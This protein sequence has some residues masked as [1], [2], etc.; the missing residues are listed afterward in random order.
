[1]NRRILRWI[2][3]LTGVAALLMLTA[4]NYAP[5]LQTVP[6]GSEHYTMIDV[7][8]TQI[9]LNVWG[10]LHATGYPLYV[11]LSAALVT[12]FRTVGISAAA[13]PALT[14][15]L[16]GMAALGLLYALM[17]KLIGASFLGGALAA[18]TVFFFGLTRSVWLHHVIAEIYTFGLLLLVVLL[19]VALWPPGDTT[20][21]GAAR[22]LFTLALI[23]GIAVGHHRAAAMAIPALIYAA[24]PWFR[25]QGRALPRVIVV[26][27][28]I[29]LLGL[30]PYGY[31]VARAAA[32]AAWVYGEPGTLAGL[33]DQFTGR[34]AARFIGGVSSLDGL[35]ANARLVT[36][37]VLTDLS[38]FG[39]LLALIGLGIGVR[40][41]STRRAA[42]TVILSGSVAYL[43]HVAF[44]T[45]V[46]AA[47]ILAAE[48]SL[49]LGW[50]FLLAYTVPRAQQIIAYGALVPRIAVQIGFL[51]GIGALAAGLLAHGEFIRGLTTDRT[52]L[53]TIPM[54]EAAPQH[55]T[56]MIAWGPRHFAAGFARDVMGTRPDVTL[57]DHT[58]DVRAALERGTVVTPEYT[59]YTFPLAWWEA[60]AG[61]RLYLSS[62]FPRLVQIAD[63]PSISVTAGGS[64][65]A[66]GYGYTCQGESWD[67]R[68]DWVAPV[69]PLPR[70]YSV[71]VHLLD[72][73]GNVIAQADQVAPVYGWY[74]FTRWTAG[75]QVRD[76]YPLARVRGGV[77]IRYGLYYQENDGTFTNVVEY[78]MTSECPPEA[79]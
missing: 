42:I 69:P 63:Q 16:W 67:V 47:L 61:A 49:A 73:D 68:I 74:P 31:L 66:A 72:A 53:D 8:E 26:C 70:D 33:W 27:L 76:V 12:A 77:R 4:F 21:E 15:W 20:R 52:A 41:P 60:A 2:P 19:V 37:V 78:A 65:T 23:G 28:G 59:F 5:T 24:A 13:A 64:V 25:M 43:F 40:A 6:N 7:G 17:R 55:S 54:L 9:V 71:F 48:L 44:Y 18:L 29:G 22:R 62:E 46:L 39:V 30:L 3:L 32:G 10:T 11:M 38:P 1:M 45:D 50:L 14:S 36:D 34:E 58:G 56:L 75:E 35:A 57:I 51:G 79:E